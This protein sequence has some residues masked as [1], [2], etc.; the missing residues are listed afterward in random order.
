MADLTQIP[1]F[2][3]KVILIVHV[4]LLTL[5]TT[6]YWAPAGYIL[7]NV[8]VIWLLYSSIYTEQI[9]PLHFALVLNSVSVIIDLFIISF[10]FP[11]HYIFSAILA[12]IFMVAKIFTSYAMFKISREK[13]ESTGPIR[14]I[15]DIFTTSKSN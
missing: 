7:I 1:N 10:H 3:T 12:I 11:N 5:A 13:T 9:D 2:P 6:G 15:G 14:S 8:I 4:I